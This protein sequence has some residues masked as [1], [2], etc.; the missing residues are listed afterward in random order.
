MIE[1]NNEFLFPFRER[2]TLKGLTN[3]IASLEVISTDADGAPLS[4]GSD[5]LGRHFSFSASPTLANISEFG[6]S[7]GSAYEVVVD[8][9]SLL[10]T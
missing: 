5:V 10:V 6:S 1:K 8:E 4:A 7:T 9:A 2:I 3:S